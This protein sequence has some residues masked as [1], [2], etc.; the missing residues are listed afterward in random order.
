MAIVP[1]ILAVKCFALMQGLKW[2][3]AVDR[4]QV[5]A[6][7]VPGGKWLVTLP[8]CHVRVMMTVVPWIQEWFATRQGLKW[9]FAVI[10]SPQV[11]AFIGPEGKVVVCTS[12]TPYQCCCDMSTLQSGSNMRHNAEAETQVFSD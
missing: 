4:P 12:L 2:E 9:E 5:N 10:E 8:S 1:C 11:N 3:I 6:C 7:V